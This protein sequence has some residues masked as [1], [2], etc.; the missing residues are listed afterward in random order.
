MEK[1]WEDKTLHATVERNQQQPKL[2]VWSSLLLVGRRAADKLQRTLKSRSQGI[3]L[4]S[5]DAW[6]VL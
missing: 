6:K 5:V 3:Y 4:Q 1:P 2:K